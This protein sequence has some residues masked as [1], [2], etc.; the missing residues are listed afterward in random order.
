MSYLICSIWETRPQVCRD[1]PKYDSYIPESCGY[2]FTGGEKKGGCYLEC[3]AQCCMLPRQDGEP[4][5]A[6]LPEI[7]GGLPCRYLED[8]D[9]PPKGAEVER[10]ED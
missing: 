10:Q 7:A 4:G 9:D 6:P 2:Y 5:G 3:Q 8:V 1:Y